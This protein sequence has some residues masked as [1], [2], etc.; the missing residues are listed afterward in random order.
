MLAYGVSLW[1]CDT[2]AYGVSLWWVCECECESVSL[3]NPNES[4]SEV[5]GC[6]WYARVVA[7]NVCNTQSVMPT[8]W[9]RW[10]SMCSIECG[11]RDISNVS[12]R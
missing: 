9:R 10:C 11:G 12:L 4:R 8:W 3:W 1:V 2:L 7:E 6:A 5:C